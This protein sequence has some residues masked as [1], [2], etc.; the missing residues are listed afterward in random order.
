MIHDN[1]MGNRLQFNKYYIFYLRE[2]TNYNQH[3][4]TWQEKSTNKFTDIQ[5]MEI[6]VGWHRAL[7]SCNSSQKVH[8]TRIM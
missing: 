2:C 5:Q 8:G 4:Q 6:L 3:F 7:Y 1:Y